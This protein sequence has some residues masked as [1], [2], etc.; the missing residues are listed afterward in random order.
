[1][2][3]DLWSF[4]HELR[5]SQVPMAEDAMAVSK[6]ARMDT[7]GLV[8]IE[9]HRTK[10]SDATQPMGIDHPRINTPLTS[11]Y[12]GLPSAKAHDVMEVPGITVG[13]TPRSQ[14]ISITRLIQTMLMTTAIATWIKN[15]D[16]AQ[17]KKYS[18]ANGITIVP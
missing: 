9:C 15:R 6:T 7:P 17:D 11:T 1:M 13:R 3:K 10:Y 12:N 14:R 16:T 2:L 4:F 18:L 5:P 8:P